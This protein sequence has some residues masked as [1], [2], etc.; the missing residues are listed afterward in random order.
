MLL[1]LAEQYLIRAE[2]RAQQDNLTGAIDDL[3]VIRNRAGIT[4][5]LWVG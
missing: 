5:L 4:P 2:A 3:N 1:R